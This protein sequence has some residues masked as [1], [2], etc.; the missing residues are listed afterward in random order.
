MSFLVMNY[1]HNVP[2]RKQQCQHNSRN[3]TTGCHWFLYSSV[4]MIV[5]KKKNYSRNSKPQWCEHMYGREQMQYHS[6][7]KDDIKYKHQGRK[8]TKLECEYS[9]IMWKVYEKANNISDYFRID[10]RQLVNK[11][12]ENILPKSQKK[13]KLSQD[14]GTESM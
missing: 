13:I 6:T 11:Y 10:K 5:S 7:G 1:K 9:N 4:V 12:M 14:P 8:N 2:E 3:K